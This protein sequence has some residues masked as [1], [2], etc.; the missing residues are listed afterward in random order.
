MNIENQEV[1]KLAN[2]GETLERHGYRFTAKA[3]SFNDERMALRL[4]REDDI[5]NL[6]LSFVGVDD[7]EDFVPDDDEGP[8]DRLKVMA[9]LTQTIRNSAD[10]P[11]KIHF[12]HVCDTFGF[13]DWNFALDVYLRAMNNTTLAEAEAAQED[14]KKSGEGQD[15]QEQESP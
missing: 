6:M 11:T 3:F 7:E 14:R 12:D 8:K 5:H 1:E 2:A 10:D 4:L 9:V 15:T 13:D